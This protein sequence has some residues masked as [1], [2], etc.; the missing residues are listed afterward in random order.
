MRVIFRSTTK[1][2]VPSK[3]GTD[4]F[5]RALGLALIGCALIGCFTARSAPAETNRIVIRVNDRIATL[6]DYE[7]ARRQL[8]EALRRSDLPP[9]RL[10]QR[11]ADV[12][13]EVM[14]DLLE[15]MLLL[16]RGDQIDA[17]P[18]PQDISEAVERARE[19]AGVRTDEEFSEGLAASGFTV[20][21]FQEHIKKNLMMSSVM[22]REVRPRIRLNE[23]DL[24]RFYQ[25]NLEDYRLPVKLNVRE[26]VVLDTATTNAEDRAAIAQD[27]SERLLAG[28]S[29]DE[30]VASS[31]EK[32]LTTEWIPIGW[33]GE[34]DLDPELE[35]AIWD[36]EIGEFSAAVPARG[37]LHLFEVLDRQEAT[38]QEF[39]VVAEEIEQQETNRRFAN[40]I[41]D[42]LAELERNSHV[43][44]E[45]PP[46]AASFR[47]VLERRREEGL[48]YDERQRALA[49]AGL[50]VVVPAEPT[51][52][53][54]ATEPLDD[55]DGT[56]P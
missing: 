10:Q 1:A 25:K 12:G 56:R 9:E 32:G 11:L 55:G 52:A 13:V 49:G 33:V 21:S 5:R 28:E 3:P 8:I 26:I 29:A 42:Y 47:S 35:S 46:E 43:V 22:G 17:R 4:R 20:E 50:N 36:L 39:S 15:E 7:K 30:V 34:G 40:E 2:F 38:I 48:E 23:E 44:I 19:Q 54:E 6:Y 14:S 18:S 24:R 16:S 31:A 53:T 27:L 37:G 41:G 51:E 45:P